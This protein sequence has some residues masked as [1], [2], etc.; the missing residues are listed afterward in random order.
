VFRASLDPDDD[1]QVFEGGLKVGGG[2]KLYLSADV[3]DVVDFIL[4]GEERR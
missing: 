3:A 2:D 4:A 1:A